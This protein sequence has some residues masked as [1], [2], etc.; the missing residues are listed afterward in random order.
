MT[1]TTLSTLL[2]LFLSKFADDTKAARVV[3][4][5]EQA[6]DLQRDLDS[7]ALW[8]SKWQILFNVD[9]CKVLHL[10]RNNKE[11]EYTMGGKKL[12]VTEEEKGLGVMIHKSLKPATQVAKAAKRANQVLGQIARDFTYRD[13]VHFIKLYRVC[14]LS[15]RVC[16]S[17]L[18]S[19]PSARHQ[20]A[21]GCP[22]KGSKNGIRAF[23]V[24]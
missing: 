9:K 5:D 11:R 7:L 15:S 21:G 14:A 17:E 3:D 8:A 13:K 12:I 2:G 18:V 20:S 22:A 1:L 6:A 19:L 16:G 24:I 23:R 10:G 4:S